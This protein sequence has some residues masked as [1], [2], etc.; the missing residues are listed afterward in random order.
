[1]AALA[2]GLALGRPVPAQD[3]Q[4]NAFERA[5][6]NDDG[7]I[8]SDEWAQFT[9]GLFEAI[10]RDGDGAASAAELGTAFEAFDY[11]RDGVIEGSEAPLVI[12]LGDADDDGRVDREEFAAIDWTR[13]SIDADG[14]GL[15]SRKEFSH[16]RRQIYDQA[17][18]DR[19]TTLGRPEYEAAPSLTLFRF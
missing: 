2:L 19:S 14:D 10:D 12:I 9:S 11:N 7:V 3:P 13:A 8:D 6:A 16:A 15:I 18:F 17:D 1:L 5:D 4:S